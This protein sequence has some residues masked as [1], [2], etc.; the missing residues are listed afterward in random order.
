MTYSC[1]AVSSSH[2]RAESQMRSLNRSVAARAFLLMPAFTFRQNSLTGFLP[3]GGWVHLSQSISWFFVDLRYSW[4]PYLNPII[5]SKF[6][7]IM[8]E[9]YSNTLS[10]LP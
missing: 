4:Y 10:F 5:I 9:F 7:S 6:S 3:E 1:L 2:I 8:F